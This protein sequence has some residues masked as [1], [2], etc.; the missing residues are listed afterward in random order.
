MQ[1][2][3]TSVPGEGGTGFDAPGG[4]LR[5]TRQQRHPRRPARERRRSHRVRQK[6]GTDLAPVKTDGF[7]VAVGQTA[8]FTS[9][10]LS[11]IVSAQHT[12]AVATATD[13]V[14]GALRATRTCPT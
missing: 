3:Q 14:I 7:D 5:P 8:G 2:V 6:V 13:E 12:T 11:I 1:H 4:L 10:G 9:N